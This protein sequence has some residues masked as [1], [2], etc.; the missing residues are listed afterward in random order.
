MKKDECF[1]RVNRSFSTVKDF[2]ARHFSLDMEMLFDKENR[3]EWMKF[4]FI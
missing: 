1:I 2:S 3:V 4:Y